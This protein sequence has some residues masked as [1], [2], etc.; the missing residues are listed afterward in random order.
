MNV[1]DGS[2]YKEKVFYGSSPDSCPSSYWF[3]WQV[4]E[5]WGD[6]VDDEKIKEWVS[7]VIK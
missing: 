6:E 4:E 1:K 5:T 3:S 2:T 7:T